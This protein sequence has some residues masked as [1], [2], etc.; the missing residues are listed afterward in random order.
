MTEY[1]EPIVKF[2]KQFFTND[3]TPPIWSLPVDSDLGKLGAPRWRAKLIRAYNTSAGKCIILGLGSNSP[4]ASWV[5][6]QDI[7]NPYRD[8]NKVYH[9]KSKIDLRLPD[10]DWTRVRKCI[11]VMLF[12][13]LTIGGQALTEN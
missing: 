9:S 6:P 1:V 2:S 7:P 13:V 5:K 8:K 4:T 3:D 12:M 10:F 11:C